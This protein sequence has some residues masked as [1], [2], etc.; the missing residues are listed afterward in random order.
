MGFRITTEHSTTTDFLDV[1]LCLETG[2]FRPFRK[3]NDHPNY[4]HVNSN[5][6]PNIIKQ[7]PNMIQDRLS[8]NSSNKELFDEAVGPYNEA[9]KRAGYRQK[10][11]YKPKNTENRNRK[12]NRQRQIV[13]WNPPYNASVTTDITRLFFAMVDRHFKG[14][15]LGKIFNRNNLKVSYRTG[16]NFKAHLDG[17]NKS[18]LNGPKVG[19]VRKCNCRQL[20]PLGGE[21]GTKN[22][23]YRADVKPVDANNNQIR[24]YFG[25]TTRPVKDRITEHKYS[26]STPKKVLSR[27]DGRVATI[28]DQIEE[29]KNK[30][31]LSAFVWKLK[32]QKQAFTIEW[33]IV[34]K[35]LPYKNGSRYCDLCAE[36]KTR[37]ALGDPTS[38][39]NSRNEIFHKCRSKTKF[40]LQYFNKPP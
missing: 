10:L 39:L 6:P 40:T 15:L 29:K 5:H 11:E 9:L 2:L 1:V 20:C 34:K 24:T 7:L 26:I 28:E 35:A 36:E 14:T 16:R 27:G 13:W 37:I 3:A 32:Q 21:C 18:K 17:H 23:I 19:E 12:K 33:K 31:E 4:I 22:V 30:S 8:T 38:T 25:Q